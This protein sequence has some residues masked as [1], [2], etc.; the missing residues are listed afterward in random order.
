MR[1]YCEFTLT[2]KPEKVE[3]CL[4]SNC[5]TGTEEHNDDG[6]VENDQEEL[7][8]LTVAMEVGPGFILQPEVEVRREG[9]STRSPCGEG[10]LLVAELD[11]DQHKSEEGEEKHQVAQLD[12]VENQ[13]A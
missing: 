12:E 1:L 2:K 9:K 7:S 6:E 5:S 4:E 11:V 10:L 3:P 13:G 8:L